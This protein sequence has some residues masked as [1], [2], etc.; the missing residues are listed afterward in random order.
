VELKKNF[1]KNT[2]ADLRSNFINQSLSEQ[3]SS[4]V[5]THSINADTGTT[6]N[7]ILLLDAAV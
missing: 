4:F 2:S 7:Y 3:P 5:A 6:G 1:R